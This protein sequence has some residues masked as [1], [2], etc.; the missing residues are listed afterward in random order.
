MILHLQPVD[1]HIL[2]FWVFRIPGNHAGFREVKSAI[3]GVDAEKGQLPKKAGIF[4][5]DHLF[6]RS[7]SYPLGRYWIAVP[8]PGKLMKLCLEVGLLGK[9]QHQGMVLPGTMDIHRYLLINVSFDLFK[10]E[11]RPSRYLGCRT[12]GSTD[13]RF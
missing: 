8:T 11:N 13:V 3:H 2:I 10:K 7:I 5:Y 4:I 1:T 6:E 12:S 9:I